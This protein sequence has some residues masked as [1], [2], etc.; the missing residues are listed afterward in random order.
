MTSAKQISA[1]LPSFFVGTLQWLGPV[2]APGRARRFAREHGKAREVFLPFVYN[3]SN[4][5][6]DAQTRALARIRRR[7]D[8]EQLPPPRVFHAPYLARSWAP[9]RFS[10]NLADPRA[11]RSN[12]AALQRECQFLGQLRAEFGID[13]PILY[14]LH[15]GCHGHQSANDSVRTAAASLTPSVDIAREAGVI[16]ALENTAERFGG[17]ELV[18]GTLAE[19][20][21]AIGMLGGGEQMDAPVGWTWDF[22]HA[23]LAYRGDVAAVKRAAASLL[24]SLVHLHVNAPHR[25]DG[26]ERWGDRHEA[27]TEQD[28]DVWHLLRLACT[29]RRFRESRTM[30][31]EVL[32][33]NALLR[34]LIGGSDIDTVTRGFDLMCRIATQA[35]SGLDEEKSLPYTADAPRPAPSTLPPGKPEPVLET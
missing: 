8:R 26:K 12:T 2:F 23:L 16:L 15:L 14:I 35:L 27:P 24:P 18:G 21:D 33:A 25:H 19:I 22:T 4:E 31:Y 9:S 30:T 10:R 3:W 5:R 34:P 1:F 6:M 13:E 17:L 32:W 28:E 11:L 29:S 20:E 7:M